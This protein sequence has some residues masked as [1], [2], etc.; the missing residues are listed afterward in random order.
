M[1]IVGSAYSQESNGKS[2]DITLLFIPDRL[3][4]ATFWISCKI[5]FT[6]ER[7]IYITISFFRN[8]CFIV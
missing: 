7:L 6:Y 2:R 1:V 8:K 5:A 3:K 4:S